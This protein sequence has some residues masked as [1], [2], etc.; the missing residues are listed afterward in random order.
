MTTSLGGIELHN[1]LFGIKKKYNMTFIRW[2]VLGGRTLW[3]SD[4]DEREMDE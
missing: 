1:T 2:S 3:M 4:M